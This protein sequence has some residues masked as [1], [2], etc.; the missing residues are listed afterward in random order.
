MLVFAAQQIEPA[1]HKQISLLFWI[2]FLFRHHRAL[3]VHSDVQK[4]LAGCLFHTQHLQ[5][6]LVNPNLLTRPAGAYL[7]WYPY[8]CSL[9]PYHH[10]CFAN[11]SSSP[12]F[13]IPQTCIHSVQFSWSVVSDALRPHEPQHARPPCPR[14]TPRAHPTSCPLSQWCHPT[15]SSSVVPFSSCPP[16]FP[17]SGS[18]QMSQI[19]ASGGQSTEISASINVH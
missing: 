17:A 13:D 12:C 10:F 19:F 2:S 5:R 7:P 15:I 1:V 11:R 8:V 9:P 18:F 4:I 3:R 6:M 14:P 16:S